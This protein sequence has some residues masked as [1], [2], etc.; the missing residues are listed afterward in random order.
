MFSRFMCTVAL[1]EFHAFLR[2]NSIPL[3]KRVARFV[4]PFTRPWTFGVLPPF[5]YRMNNAAVNADVQ[6]PVEVPAFNSFGCISRNE[7]ARVCGNFMFNFSEELPYCFA[8]ATPF[9]N[10]TGNG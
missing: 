6:I 5:N 10:P 3:Q 7:T 8:V 2:L 1:S 9:Y 4:D